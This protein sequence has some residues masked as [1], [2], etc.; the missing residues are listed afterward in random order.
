MDATIGDPSVASS[1]ERVFESQQVPGLWGQVTFRSMAISVVLGTVFGFV[2]LRIMMK[3]GILQA[4]NMPINVL[5]FFFLKWVINLLRACGFN[6]L[7]FSRQ[8]NV[9]ILTTVTTC[10][11]VAMSGGFAN[12]VIGMTPVVAKSLGVD[13]PDPRDVVDYIP[14]GR[15]M[16]FLFVIS[17]VGIMTSV[18]LNKVMIVDYRLLFPTGTV[19]AHLVNSFHTPQG[20]HVA[21]LQV[22]TIFKFFLGSMSWTI[23]SWLYSAGD[24]CGFSNFPIFG[25]ELYKHRFKFD[26][27]PTFLGVG[28]ICPHVINL[29][30]LFGAIIS[31]GFVYPFLETKHGEW[32]HTD[33]ASSLK[34]MN[35]YKV[36]MCIAVIITD[37]LFNFFTVIITSYI[38]IKHKQQENDSGLSN[39]MKKHPSLNYDDRK[40]IEVFLKNKIPLTILVGGYIASATVST[41]VVPWLFNQIKFYHVA[42]LYIITPVIAFANTYA[43]GLT[44]WSVGYTYGK[45]TIFVIAA[46][47]VK[48]GAVVAGLVACGIMIAALHISSQATQ[49]IKT[50]FMTLTSER[51]MVI[52]QI[53]GVIIGSVV[54]PCIFLAFQKGEKPNVPIGSPESHYPCPFAGLFRAIGV[55]GTGGVKELPDYCLWMCFG[56]FCITIATNVLSLV[57]QRKGWAIHKYLPNMTVVALPFFA[58]PDFAIDMCL[59]S[60][61]MFLWHKMNR[62]NAD[63]FSSAVAAGLICGEGL[64]ALPSAVLSMFS[65][66]PPMCM[67]FLPSGKEVDVVNSFLNKL[68]APTRT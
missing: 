20:A 65:V 22:A 42:T 55:I 37:G 31:W 60:L 6:T 39:Y 61:V 50:G 11:N 36:F 1:V 59:G 35:G 67:K 68:E 44:D 30:L 27:S 32:Y 51:A 52:G 18:P 41:I 47:I 24:E 49:D 19:Q 7:P 21:K 57:S 29:A 13:N 23:F 38:D 16:L 54:N 46:W 45:F 15:W 14:T 56:A 34:G 10:L 2:G 3:A 9:V 5:S 4:L 8:E 33:S 58:G 43:N 53:V 40:R 62:R 17:M 48:A 64:F 63:L 25:L 12:Y 66:Q 28:M 26:F